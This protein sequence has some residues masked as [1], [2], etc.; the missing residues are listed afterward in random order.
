MRPMLATP[1]TEVPRGEAWTH[2]VKWDGMR[3]LAEV[4]AGAPAARLTSRNENDV[5]PA[6]PDVAVSPLPGRDLVVDGEVIALDARGVPD[7]RVLQE[8]MHVRN[9]R[10]VAR[11]VEQVPVT[12][13]AFDLLRLDG[14]DLTARPL[15]ERRALLE[16]ALD[17]GAWQVPPAYDD[18]EMLWEATAQQGLEGIVSKRRDSRY[19]PG[20]R[21]PHWLKR[22]HRHRRSYVV[23]GWRPQEG[24]SDRLAALLVGE[25][26]P[27]GLAYRGRVGSGI[28]ARA[29]RA[30]GALVVDL[31]REQSPFH[32]EVP[33]VDAAGTHWVEPRLV[34]DVDTHGAG[35][36]RL[37]QP[38]FR[39]LRED[40]APEDLA[41]G[42]LR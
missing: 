18:G 16:E 13:M 11:L 10:T 5:T 20:E 38:S 39:G 17:G 26:T 7:F 41:E 9:R 8:R 2:E 27:A 3:L 4:T 30:L 15:Q 37:R 35:Y 42:T 31:A 19:R 1:A 12:F 22:A 6:W 40:L 14:H 25:P 28:G 32:D 24:T 33:R 29:G 34:V 23:G 36:Q 21:S